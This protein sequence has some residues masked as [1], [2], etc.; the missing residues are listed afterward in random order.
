M[1]ERTGR[2]ECLEEYMEVCYELWGSW[3]PDTII[4]DRA[5]GIY[6]DPG[7]V[8]TVHHEGQFYRCHGR[9]VCAPSLHGRPVLWQA[10]SSNQGRDFAAKH[11]EAI[12]AAMPT[13]SPVA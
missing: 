11:A 12:F 9:H 1:T 8:H 7:K 10:G 2:Y 5:S 6:A 3:E 13:V 4:A